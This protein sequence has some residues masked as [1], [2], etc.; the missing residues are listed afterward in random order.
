MNYRPQLW[1]ASAL[2]LA[3][4]VAVAAALW[5][6]WPAPVPVE[7]PKP[8]VM[9]DDGSLIIE[10]APTTPAARPQQRLPRGA[11]V[12][13]ITTVT[14]RPDPTAGND[15]AV[16]MTLVRESDGGRRMIAS[17]PDG[18]VVG[19]LDIPVDTIFPA[20]G[21]WAA[22]LSLDPIHQTPGVWLERD[23][24]RLRIGVEANR[25]A[26]RGDGRGNELR[27]RVGWVF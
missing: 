12:E 25:V 24:R 7:Q 19:G 1:L 20:S 14:V 3:A 4:A 2:V 15:I 27:L 21:T 6:L 11:R 17:S 10:R 18:R 22:G 8:A 23:L 9:Q 26:T 13:R 5:W 16:D